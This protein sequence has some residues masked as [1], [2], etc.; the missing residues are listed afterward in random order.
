MPLYE[1][2]C[3]ECGEVFQKVIRLDKYHE[4]SCPKCGSE[5][6][7][8]FINGNGGF[9]LETTP[10]RETGFYDLDHGKKATWDLTVPGKLERLRKEGRIKDYF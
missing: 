6:E 10:G 7:Q 8:I 1:F 2:R 9:S 3:K 4:P 5:T